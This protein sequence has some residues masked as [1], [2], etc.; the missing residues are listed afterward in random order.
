MK[1]KKL[2]DLATEMVGD[3]KKKNVFFVTVKGD[4]VLIAVDFAQAYGYWRSL[5]NTRV[6][7]ML[8]DR[9]TGVLADAG[10]L[11]EEQPHRWEVHDDTRAFGFRS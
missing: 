5:A 8:E 11:N 9:Q 1:V 2:N 10:Y 4:V 7:C 6:Q 3:G